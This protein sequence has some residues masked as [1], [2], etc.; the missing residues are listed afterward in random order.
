MTEIWFRIARAYGIVVAMASFE[1]R[2]KPHQRRNIRQFMFG[3]L[4]RDLTE[5]QRAEADA[6][7]DEHFRWIVHPNRRPSL[8]WVLDTA[9]VAVVRANA[10]VLVIDPWNRLESDRPDRQR[11][12]E[13]ISQ[14]LD[15]ILDFARDMRCHVM[16]IA[17]P[18]KAMSPEQRKYR[19]ALEDIA[20][21]KAWD[22]KT[23]LGLCVHRPVMFKDGERQTE[24]QLHVL[25]SRFD[26]L[27]Y[28]CVLDLDYDLKTGCYRSTD[29]RMAYEPRG[30]AA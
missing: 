11:E 12:T 26:E 8:K 20:G 15:E 6:W 23:D 9:E 3:Q 4:D 7:N 27:G 14:A 5:E 24:A 2:A 19:P 18:A 25:K 17:H 22:T 21:S 13:Y 16:I 30:N 29:Y 10:R 1:T 28:P